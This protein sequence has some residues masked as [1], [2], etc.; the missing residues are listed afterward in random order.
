MIEEIRIAAWGGGLTLYD[1]RFIVDYWITTH[2]HERGL[3]EILEE[4]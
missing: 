2:S 1:L 4:T 3:S